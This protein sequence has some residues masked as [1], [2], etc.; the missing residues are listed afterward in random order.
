MKNNKLTQSILAIIAVAVLATLTGCNSPEQ[1]TAPG[2]EAK[3]GKQV[4]T[5]NAQVSKETLE[6]IMTP[7]QVETSIGTLNFLDG[8]PYSDTAE[9]VYDELDRMRGVEAYL[10]GMPLASI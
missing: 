2:T 10:K 6:S 7:D 3:G 9:K 1:A 4:S 8:A 5:A